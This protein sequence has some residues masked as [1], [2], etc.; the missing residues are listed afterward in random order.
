MNKAVKKLLIPLVNDILQRPL[1]NKSVL[2]LIE[3]RLK[4]MNFKMVVVWFQKGDLIMGKGLKN[5]LKQF[6]SKNPEFYI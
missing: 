3:E 1:S 5:E 2:D 4:K 6:Y